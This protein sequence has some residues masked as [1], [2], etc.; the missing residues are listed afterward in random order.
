MRLLLLALPT[1]ALLPQVIPDY[2]G[3]KKCW[4][5][6]GNCRKKCED[7]EVIKEM[8]NSRRICC[9]PGNKSQWQVPKTTPTPSYDSTSILFD[10]ILTIPSTTYYFDEKSSKVTINDF[11]VVPGMQ[12]SPEAQDVLSDLTLNPTVNEII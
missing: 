3:G 11:E 2:G 4:N 10:V 12:I 5:K 1:L 9:I 8:C 6:A 7:G